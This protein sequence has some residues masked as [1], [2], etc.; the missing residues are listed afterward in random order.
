MSL[1]RSGLVFGL[2]FVLVLV[3]FFFVILVLF[4]PGGL[5]IQHPPCTAGKVD[6]GLFGDFVYRYGGCL[7]K[8]EKRKRRDPAIVQSGYTRKSARK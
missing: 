7:K 5:P 4:D 1:L 6:V 2:T 3:V 8:A